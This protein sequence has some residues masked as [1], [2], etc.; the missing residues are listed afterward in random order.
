MGIPFAKRS[1]ARGFTL[2]ELLVVIAIIGI[3]IAMLLPAVQNARESARILSCKNN[4]KQIGLALHAYHHANGIL[5]YGAN[6]PSST[7]GTWASAILPQLDEQSV[8]DKFDFTKPVWDTVDR[9]SVV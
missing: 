2:V 1:S 9:K 8:Y 5:P 6:F 3:L 7:G 4:L